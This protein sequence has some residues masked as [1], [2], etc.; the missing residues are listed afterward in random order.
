MMIDTVHVNIER[1]ILNI[2]M[3]MYLYICVCVCVCLFVYFQE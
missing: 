3:L 2:L 1:N